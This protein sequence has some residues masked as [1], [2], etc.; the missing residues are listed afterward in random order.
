ME[1]ECKQENFLG[2]VK[3]F[4]NNT[5]G[6]RIQLGAIVLTIVVQIGGF[7]FYAGGQKEVVSQ[8][9]KTTANLD[10]K[11]SNVKLVGYVNAAEK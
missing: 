7:L 9:Q 3:E 2:Q 10:S 1:H 4:I 5:K 6:M 11:F 8:L